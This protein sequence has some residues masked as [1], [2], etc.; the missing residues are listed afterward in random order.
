MATPPKPRP[1]APVR[2]SAKAAAKA[3]S[4]GTRAPAGARAAGAATPRWSGVP[5]S[6]DTAPRK[7]RFVDYPRA[8]KSGVRRW[9]PS[10][11][12]VL[13]SFL[14]VLFLVVGVV[15]A[16]YTS[17]TI[18]APQDMVFAQT[19]TVYYADGKTE[20]GRFA[21]ENRE[22]VDYET[23]P[24][25]VGL[26]VVA[27]EDQT[28]F[29]NSGVDPVGMARALWNNVRY[30]TKQGGS[31]LTQQYAERYYQGTT[32]DYVGKFREALLAV[33][34]AQT[35]DKEEILGNYL[36]TIYFGRG[37]YG[38]QAAAQAYFRVDAKDLTVEQAAVLAGVIPAP[39]RFDPRVD[40]EQGERRWNYVLDRMT[41]DG[42]VDAT[43]REAMTFPKVKKY[44]QSDTYGGTQGYLLSMVRKELVERSHFTEDEIDTAGLRITT[45]IDPRIQEAAVAVIDEIPDDAPERLRTAVVTI[46]PAD[47]A[48]LGLYGG[49]DYVE[50]PQNAVTQD[51]AQAGSTFKPFTLVA[52]LEEGIS[53]RTTYDGNSP[54]FVEGFPEERGVRN[55]GN[56]S[57][58]TVDLVEATAKSVNTA[59]AALN[60]EIGPEKA[61]DAAIRLGLPENTQ[62]L[63]DNPANVLGTAAPHPLDMA[64]AYA[65]IA[66]G[67]VHHEPF[68]VRE[69]SY[70]SGGIAYEGA[71]VGSRAFDTDVMAD[72]TFAMAQVVEA[73]S[74]TKVK[75]LGRPVAGKT[76]SSTDNLSAW[77][78]GFTPQMATAIA[79]YQPDEAGNPESITPFGGYT[80]MTGG[81]V[82][83]DL[84]TSYMGVALEGYEI[85]DF[86][87]RADVGV[88][89]SPSPSPS[90]TDEEDEETEDE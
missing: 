9:L 82:P 22:I 11:R 54:A 49:H 2:T 46:D 21:V 28:F 13:G 18:P 61:R 78:V 37:A 84:W 63:L 79:M 67:G 51:I 30:G 58:G 25:H 32:R 36:N 10:W 56:T 50:H 87:P 86:P 59:Y 47:G 1:G 27:A 7:R 88:R 45:T 23:L 40:P 72:T 3:P 90:E 43:E 55:F 38:V 62:D 20:M 70:L 26:A 33:K 16:A 5:T 66:A 64:E 75:A 39:S 89:P 69:A 24:E 81:T 8:G 15:V 44:K 71:E 53:L 80:E 85:E 76:G 17:T 57:F 19:T 35:Q 6:S 65:T 34:I 29:E 77:F 73:G 41:A 60:V 48:I 52:A 4:P 42:Y 83:T 74:A 12:L 31:T 68:I 14:V